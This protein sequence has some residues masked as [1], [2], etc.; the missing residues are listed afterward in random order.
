[1]SAP[2]ADTYIG[3]CQNPAKAPFGT[4]PANHTALTNIYASWRTTVNAP[5]RTT[6]W[7]SVQNHFDDF[8]GG[9][10]IFVPNSEG[11]LRLRIIHGIRRYTGSV[12]SSSAVDNLVF[13]YVGD[14]EEA[15][16]ELVTFNTDMCKI[17]VETNIA[18]TA[19][20][21]ATLEGDP[22]LEILPPRGDGAAQIET[23]TTRMTMYVPFELIPFLMKRDLSPR[24]AFLIAHAQLDAKGLLDVC[25]PLL[26]FF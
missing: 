15:M 22:A 20:H 1:M 23:V 13:G 8:A 19:H 26:Q 14:I 4:G 12:V 3:Y 9:V 6:L 25:A 21:K 5:S 2:I 10:G 24:E 7:Q 16:G 17:T 18:T 11:N